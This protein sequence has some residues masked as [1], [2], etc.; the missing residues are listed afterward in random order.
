M[1]NKLQGLKSNQAVGEL[2][3]YSFWSILG[4]L[5]S[6]ILLFFIWIVV[7]RLL[8][9]ER[10]GEFSIIRS[11]TLLFADFVGFSFGIAATKYIAQYFGHDNG[12]IKRLIG[13]FLFYGVILGIL[14]FLILYFAAEWICVNLLNAEHLTNLLKYTSI[15]MLVS[16]LN[17]SQLGILRGLNLYKEITYINVI[18]ILC[19]FP[20]YVLGTYFWGLSGAV[21]AYIWYNIIICI[22][23][24]YVIR[25][26][27]KNKNIQPVYKGINKEFQVILKYA[28]P[29]FLS[30][31]LTMLA[32]WYNESKLVSIGGQGFIQ[33]GYYSAVNVIQTMVI[34]IT[35]MICIPFVSMMSK[36]NKQKESF[37]LEK[38]NILLPLYLG[39]TIAIPIMI[40]PE[41]LS[42]FYGENFANE[43]MYII[44]IIMIS[45][46]V[47]II[48]K[49]ALARLVAVYEMQWFYL[50]DSLLLCILF[51]VGFCGLSYLGIQG[52]VITYLISYIISSFIFT[53]LYIKKR[54][55]DIDIFKD[56]MFVQL[57]LFVVIASFTYKIFPNIWLRIGLF[58]T[59]CLA[60][61]FQLREKFKK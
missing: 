29:Y 25:K 19:S 26:F 35:I 6:K 57:S 1:F 60:I 11:T 23:A 16:T 40:F 8:L 47:L 12:K 17:N 48:Y 9:A 41:I 43:E 44:T 20:V 38:L 32:Q 14:L 53:P 54:M 15:V 10:Y 52:L 45:Y 22:L 56:K 31:F 50:L 3:S 28:L 5:I 4:T 24:Q 59:L 18:H 36:Y 33:L 21:V 37:V 61:F 30:M 58:L 7:A 46:S 42:I 51:I 49:Q 2:F 13:A 55:I 34:G 39:V 27:C